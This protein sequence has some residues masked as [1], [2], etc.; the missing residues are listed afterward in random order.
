MTRKPKR[1]PDDPE[2]YVRFL[3]AAKKA[4]GWSKSAHHLRAQILY[5]IAE[6]LSVRTRAGGTLRLAATNSDWVTRN[7]VGT[8]RAPSNRSVSSVSE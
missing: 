7:M 3:E 4:E 2:Q 1:P 6:N 5:Y 8:S